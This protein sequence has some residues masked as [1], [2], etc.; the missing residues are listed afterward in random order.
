MHEQPYRLL[1]ADDNRDMAE[2][3]AAL[4]RME[5]HVAHVAFD[6]ERALEIAATHELH[7]AVLD[8]EMP[9]LNGYEVARRLRAAHSDLIL[10]ALTG[11]TRESEKAA[12]R[13][14][15]FDA[16]LMKPLEFAQFQE[17]LQRLS[18]KKP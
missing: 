14:A 10:I 1:V 6:G 17:L 5:G 16:F 11:W 13:A 18:Q 4:V 8:I 2:T 9:R 7:V 12:A 15:G 3:F